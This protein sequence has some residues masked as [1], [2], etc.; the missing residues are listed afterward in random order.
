VKSYGTST[1]TILI[2]NL[3]A[4]GSTVLGALAIWLFAMPVAFRLRAKPVR[5][6]PDAGSTGP[7]F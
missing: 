5:I 1:E 2:V 6:L 3:I 7:S 4:Y